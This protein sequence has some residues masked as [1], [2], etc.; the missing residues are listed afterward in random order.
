MLMHMFIK[1]Q[2]LL[3]LD[4]GCNRS[5]EIESQRDV[6]NADKRVSVDRWFYFYSDRRPIHKRTS[7]SFRRIYEATMMHLLNA[8]FI[9]TDKIYTTKGEP[10][11]Q[12]FEW[13]VE[14]SSARLEA[15]RSFSAAVAVAYRNHRYCSTCRATCRVSLSLSLVCWAKIDWPAAVEC[16]GWVYLD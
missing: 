1:Y 12:A 8:F 3:E 15:I 9:V 14:L 7:F 13:S 2:Q 4:H 10:Y 16:R 5:I 6:N 11:D